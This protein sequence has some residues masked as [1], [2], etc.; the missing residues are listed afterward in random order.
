M[1]N[2]LEIICDGD[3][4]V[5]GSEIVDPE[6]VKQHPPGVYCGEYDYQEENDSYR[7]PLIFPRHLGE[8]FDAN[9]TNLSWPADDN[10]SILTRTMSYVCE[11]YL[12]KGKSTEN[13]FVMIGWSSPERNSFWY[14]DEN[15]S[16]PFRL[17][18]HVKNFETP[19][20]E[21]FWKLYVMYL[22]NQEEYITRHVRNVMQFQD[23]CNSHNIKWL[24]WNSFYQDPGAHVDGWEDLDMNATLKALQHGVGGFQLRRSNELTR[25]S[26][27][28]N[29]QA[30][31]DTVDDVRFYKKNEP[32]NTFKSYI[33]ANKDTIGE[34]FVGLHP[35]PPAHKAWANELYRYI[36]EHN[37]L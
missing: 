25:N 36:N 14:K 26:G 6:L 11:H 34:P 16:H 13:L 27:M 33:L 35:N 22:Y 10:N 4:W 17:W 12:S 21:E 32:N 7:V 23:F 9:V 2:K 29:L 3:S 28:I 18:P 31:W 8:L 20:Q 24:C 1:Q 19:Q 5:F 15:I 30:M 37:L